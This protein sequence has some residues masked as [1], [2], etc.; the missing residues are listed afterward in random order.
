[1]I[2]FVCDEQIALAIDGQSTWSVEASR[3]AD[4]IY[5]TRLARSTRQGD[6][7]PGRDLHLS[8]RGR[9]RNEEISLAIADKLLRIGEARV[10]SD[11]IGDAKFACAAGHGGDRS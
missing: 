5:I 1:M 6:Y 11:S 4:A 3:D 8:D 7:S 10:G 9:L 2:L